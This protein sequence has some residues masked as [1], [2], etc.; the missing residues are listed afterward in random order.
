MTKPT[1]ALPWSLL[2]VDNL[3]RSHSRRIQRRDFRSFLM[4]VDFP[5]WTSS[6]SAQDRRPHDRIAFYAICLRSMK[7]TCKQ[8]AQVD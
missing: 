1:K 2:Q 4:L 8:L 5:Q 3:S 6:I 7:P